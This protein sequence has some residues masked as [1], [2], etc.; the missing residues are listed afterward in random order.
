MK[1][2][3]FVLVGTAVAFAAIPWLANGLEW[4]FR[5]YAT[6]CKWVCDKTRFME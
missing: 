5:Y 2:A 4:M 3:L 1:A 6:Y